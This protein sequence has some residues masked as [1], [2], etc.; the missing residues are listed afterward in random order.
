MPSNILSIDSNFPSFTGEESPQQQIRMLHNYLFQ[1]REGLQYSLQNLTADN[2][3][4][5]ALQ[6]M[7]EA[8][9]NEVTAE[10]QKVY[11]LLNQ[12][13]GEINSI[14]SRVSGMENL[15]GRVGTAEGDIRDLK[16]RTGAAEQA[17]EGLTDWMT[18]AEE[19]IV[20]LQARTGEAEE[21]IEDL[22]GRV[23]GLE[24]DTT[25]TD[26]KETVTGVGGL[27]DLVEQMQEELDKIAAAVAVAE[28]GGVTLGSEGKPL[29][30]VGQVYINGVLIEQ[31]GAT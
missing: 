4:A 8:Q 21:H 5:A 15:A 19:R 1:L 16:D 22:S 28:D 27:K 25:L 7:N 24:D 12:M 31:G 17:I 14:S 18:T 26:L 2:F 10:L 20:D 29:R 30:L 23:K 9:K 6:N 3:N 13:A 11:A